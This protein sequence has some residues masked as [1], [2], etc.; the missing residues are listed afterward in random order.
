MQ[1]K[2]VIEL[3]EAELEDTSVQEFQLLKGVKQLHRK[4]CLFGTLANIR[5]DLTYFHKKQQLNILDKRLL[6]GIFEKNV[7]FDDGSAAY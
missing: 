1:R 7:H 2:N 5:Q 4:S 6:L 3:K